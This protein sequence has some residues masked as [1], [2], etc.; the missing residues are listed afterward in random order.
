M[1]AGASRKGKDFVMRFWFGLLLLVPGAA[2]AQ[3]PAYQLSEAD[4][5][6]YRYVSDGAVVTKAAQGTMNGS[7]RVDAI[8]VVSGDEADSA[9][10][11]LKRLV[12]IQ[13]GPEGMQRPNTDNVLGQPFR[14]HFPKSGR[15]SV[16]RAPDMSEEVESMADVSGQL[17]SMFISL[18]SSALTS[19][20]AWKDTLR[21][22]KE[23]GDNKSES[24]TIREFQVLRDT[25]V[26]ETPAVVIS[27]IQKRKLSATRVLEE[28]GGRADIDLKGDEEGIA[29]FAPSIGRLLGRRS[30]G[31]L[32]GSVGFEGSGSRLAFSQTIN[33][34]NTLDLLP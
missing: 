15:V 3:A 33:Y 5:L 9:T 13:R 14:L 20:A 4:T 10:A 12:V 24:T 16:V 11:S 29:V 27:V 7:V 31:K 6:R 1:R 23:D 19:G 2:F 32:A 34:T 18:P 25:L 21:R 26:S 22:Q 17:E 30:Q 8:A 28:Q